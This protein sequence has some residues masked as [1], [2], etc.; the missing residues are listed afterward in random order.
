MIDP[1]Y[2]RVARAVGDADEALLHVGPGLLA[3]SDLPAE[4]LARTVWGAPDEQFTAD[5]L[6]DDPEGVWADWL[7]FWEDAGVEPGGVEPEPVH[8]RV[9]ELVEAG[10]V[11]T[12]LTE[13]VFGQLRAAGVPSADCVEFHG[14]ADRA[15]CV[16]CERAYDADLSGTVG[17]RGCPACGGTLGPGVILAGEPPARR[18]RLRAYARAEGCGAYLAAGTSLAVDPTAE[19]AEHAV[20]TG[21]SLLVV[22]DRPTALDDAADERLRQEPAEALARLRDALAIMGWD[23]EGDAGAGPGPGS[24]SSRVLDD[25]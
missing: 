4:E 9:A 7:E 5:R 1:R 13:N 19:N 22:G 3:G 14:R 20:E 11:S 2:R 10:H 12:V 21:A 17:H 6:R 8:E 24:G 18:D 25:R 15:R 23:R 16:R